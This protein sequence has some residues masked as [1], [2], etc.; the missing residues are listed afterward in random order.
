MKDLTSKLEE[1]VANATKAAKR[2]VAKLQQRVRVFVL[3]W[4]VSPS[5]LVYSLY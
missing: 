5:L 3:L 4:S 2:E 1:Q